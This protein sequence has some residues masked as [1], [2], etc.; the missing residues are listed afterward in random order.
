MHEKERAEM[1]AVIGDFLELGHVENIMAMFRQDPSL[2]AL[3]GE[4]LRDERFRV[5]MGMAV[6]FEEMMAIHPQE[7]ALAIPS[8]L[9]V[10]SEETVWMRGEAVTLLGIIGTTEALAHL[11]P[12]AD[13]PEPQIR[14]MVGDILSEK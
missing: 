4:L 3:S 11:K 7:V 12:L 2:Y 10:L 8:L 5:R 14:E 13:D 9:P 6:L 1:I